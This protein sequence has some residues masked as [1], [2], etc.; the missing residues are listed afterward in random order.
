MNERRRLEDQLAGLQHRLQS[1]HSRSS[2]TLDTLRQQHT[3]DLSNLSDQLA[4][5]QQQARTETARLSGRLESTLA[6]V[7]P[8]SKLPFAWP[9]K[10]PV[11]GVPV[12][13]VDYHEL[14]LA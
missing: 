8:Y 1:D 11:G 2:T 6:E 9:R 3:T 13:Q 14:T 7:W 5:T 10:C 12:M 4:A